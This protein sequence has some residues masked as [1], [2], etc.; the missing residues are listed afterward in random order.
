MVASTH[1]AAVVDEPWGMKP[2]GRRS[3]P[4][5]KAVA[6]RGHPGPGVTLDAKRRLPVALPTVEG[7][8][9]GVHGVLVEV[10]GGVNRHRA[11][12]GGV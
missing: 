1:Q 11:D 7:R 2:V 6:G 4:E 9:A 3:A 5:V 8:A 12:P 10:I